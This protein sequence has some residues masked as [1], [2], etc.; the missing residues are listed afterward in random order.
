MNHKW[1]GLFFECRLKIPKL[2]PGFQKYTF[3][4]ILKL[5]GCLLFSTIKN[6]GIS[7]PDPTILCLKKWMLVKESL[8]KYKCYETGYAELPEKVTV[9]KNTCL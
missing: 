5:I 4:T 1:H 3:V 9:S 2:L 7:K 6:W 8:S